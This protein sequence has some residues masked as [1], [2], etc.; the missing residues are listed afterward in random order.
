MGIEHENVTIRQDFGNLGFTVLATPIND[1]VVR[2]EIYEI[3]A[4]RKV[5]NESATDVIVWRLKDDRQAF[6]ADITKARCFL[7][8]DV[9]WDGCS[10]WYFN[11]QDNA[12]LHFCSLRE[13]EAISAIMKE[14]WE[15]AAGLISNWQGDDKPWG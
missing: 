3:V 12:M 14:C 11:Q 6:T 1:C 15:L 5:T 4:H 9:K 13:I 8:G 2:F 10:N 7:N